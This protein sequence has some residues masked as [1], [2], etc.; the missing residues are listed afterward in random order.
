[1]NVALSR[2]LGFK[3]FLS[4]VESGRYRKII[5]SPEL[6]ERFLPYA[7]AFRVEK[8]W[9]KSVRGHLSRAAAMVCRWNRTVQRVELLAQHQRHVERSGEQHVVESGG[10]GSG[11]GGGGSSGGGSG[12]GGGSG[13]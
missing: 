7:M 10:S 2:D 1:M 8:N 5:T 6:F 4:R 9:A 12:G 11:S 13:F 3:E